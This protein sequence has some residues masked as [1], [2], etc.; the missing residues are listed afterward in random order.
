MY[1]VKRRAIPDPDSDLKATPVF[2]FTAAT[3]DDRV[4]LGPI[5]QGALARD[6]VF[7]AFDVDPQDLDR[8]SVVL[9]EP[10]SE[11][12]FRPRDAAGTPLGAGATHGAAFAKAT[13]DRKTRVAIDGPYLE[14]LGLRL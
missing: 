6:L 10:P 12:R 9:D 11:L 1:L 8:Y 5:F 4:C 13:I 7:F 3:R 2:E 14:A